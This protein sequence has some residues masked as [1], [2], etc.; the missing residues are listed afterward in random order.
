MPRA[1]PARN[2]FLSDLRPSRNCFG[3]RHVAKARMPQAVGAQPFVPSSSGRRAGC[4]SSAA[5]ETDQ[6]ERPCNQAAVR[7]APAA[8]NAATR[9]PPDLSRDKPGT[10]TN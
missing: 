1:P 4:P 5:S 9:A 6:R 3:K 7:F 10:V 8:W 2:F